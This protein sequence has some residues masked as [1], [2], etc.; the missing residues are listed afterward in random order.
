MEEWRLTVLILFFAMLIIVAGASFVIEDLQ[1]KIKWKNI[2]LKDLEDRLTQVELILRSLAYKQGFK[3]KRNTG[4]Y[5]V[6][7]KNKK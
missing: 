5:R 6:V 4:E 7:K 2:E 3:I 1:D